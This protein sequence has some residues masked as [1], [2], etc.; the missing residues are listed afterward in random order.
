[1]SSGNEG[2]EPLPKRKHVRLKGYDYSQNGCYFITVCTKD[3][4]PLLSRIVGRGLAPAAPCQVELTPLGSILHGQILA[5]E[6][7]FPSVEINHFVI[8]P[9]HF[10]ALLSIGETAGASPRPT[11]SALVGVCK[12]L[13]TRLANQSDGT[14]GR[15]IF[16]TSFHDHVVRN[17]AD[18]DAHWVYID[19]NPA[20]WVEDEYYTESNTI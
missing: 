2:I 7:R 13:T 20:R 14:P 3:R 8:M 4:K 15:V 18:Y 17:D 5:L 1:M 19:G 9:N 6:S 11:L 12:S 10:H 16:Q